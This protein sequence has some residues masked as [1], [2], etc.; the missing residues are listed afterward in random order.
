MGGKRYYGYILLIPTL[1]DKEPWK[2][3]CIDT[4]LWTLKF[5]NDITEKITKK[6]FTLLTIMDACMTWVEFT[7]LLHKIDQHVAI[8]FEKK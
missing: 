3:V 4:G 5:D 7:P 1:Q 8:K 6:H 2:V